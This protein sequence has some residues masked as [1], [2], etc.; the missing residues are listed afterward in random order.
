VTIDIPGPAEADDGADGD[1]VDHG[2]HRDDFLYEVGSGQRGTRFDDHLIG[3]E[4][5]RGR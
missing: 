1:D 3:H 2:P 5:R 4:G